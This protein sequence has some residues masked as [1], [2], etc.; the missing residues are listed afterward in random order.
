MLKRLPVLIT[1]IIFAV[2]VG[3]YVV[4]NFLAVSLIAFGQDQAS[5][6]AAARFAPGNPEV[7]A[8]RGK[9]LL[10]RSEPPR[11]REAIAELERAVQTSP[12]DYRFWLE[13]GRA[14]ENTGEVRRAEIALERARRLAPGYFETRWALANFRLRAGKLDQAL[15]DFREAIALSGGSAGVGRQRPDQNALLNALSTLTGMLGE[16]PQRLSGMTPPDSFSQSHL[17]AFLAARNMVE[18]AMEIWRR[19]PAEEVD[20]YRSAGFDTL[21]ELQSKNRYAEMRV[22]WEKIAGGSGASAS[23]PGGPANLITNPGFEQRPMSEDY[24]LL[25]EFQTGF[26]WIV[27][28]HPEV[29]VRRTG[30]VRRSG[31]YALHLSFVAPMRSEFEEVSQLVAVEPSRVYRLSFYVKTKNVSTSPGQAPLVELTDP[32]QPSRLAIRLAVTG[33]TGDWAELRAVFATPAETRGLRLIMRCPQIRIIDPERITEVWF[34][35]FKLN[36]EE[37]R[38]D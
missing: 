10:Y 13:L 24:P 16:D 2:W 7:I 23:D 20:S 25:A 34:D 11:P 12:R 37:N 19:L 38:Q 29:R 15:I 33:G 30:S 18:P 4:R 3:N 8:A 14:Y 27:R 17:A 5:R 31:D 28:Q 21:R 35:D 6:E 32:Q 36:R 1:V 26:D 22:V 9:Y